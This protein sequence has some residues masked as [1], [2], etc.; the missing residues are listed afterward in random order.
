LP[1]RPAYS[2]SLS[3]P[4][5]SFL[6]YD[7][8]IACCQ[9]QTDASA[10]SSDE[11]DTRLWIA[12][13]L[14]LDTDAI[15][16]RHR[17]VKAEAFGFVP[18]FHGLVDYVQILEVLGEDNNLITWPLFGQVMQQLCQGTN[19]WRAE[20]LI[21]IQTTNSAIDQV[22]AKARTTKVHAPPHVLPFSEQENCFVQ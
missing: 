2:L 21:K 22:T 5:P 13:E 4:V 6:T 15:L 12:L 1:H 14:G 3:R 11:K 17:S 10:A 20:D 19:V 16:L 8:D 18:H 7:G 9:I